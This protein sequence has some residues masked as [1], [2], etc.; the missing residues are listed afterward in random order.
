VDKIVLVMVTAETELAYV[1]M[2][3]VEEIVASLQT[4]LVNAL[5]NVFVDVSNNVLLFMIFKEH[6]LHMIVTVN[7][8]KLVFHNVWLENHQL[9]LTTAVHFL[10]SLLMSSL[11]H[12]KKK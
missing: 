2:D 7:A 3:I 8:H 1:K 12:K 10:S 11:T 6:N 4:N 9:N 5:L